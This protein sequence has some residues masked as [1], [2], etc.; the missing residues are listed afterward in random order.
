[1]LYFSSQALD[2][3]QLGFTDLVNNGT[4]IAFPI[5]LLLRR[6]YDS[7]SITLVCCYF[8]RTIDVSVFQIEKPLFDARSMSSD[9]TCLNGM[10]F[11]T[12]N[13][14]CS[15]LRNFA[16]TSIFCQLCLLQL[17]FRVRHAEFLKRSGEI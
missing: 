12:D 6:K 15:N 10:K 16:F 13:L 8:R 2:A 9:K 1:M 7:R 11:L 3:L 5:C 4:A 14:V 17:T